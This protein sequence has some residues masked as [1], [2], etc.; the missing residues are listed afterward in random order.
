MSTCCNSADWSDCGV[1]GKERSSLRLNLFSVYFADVNVVRSALTEIGRQGALARA[2]KASQINLHSISETLKRH[3]TSIIN[4][5]GPGKI[6]LSRFL[7]CLFGFPFSRACKQAG[8]VIALSM[9]AE[10]TLL[11][12]IPVIYVQFGLTVLYSSVAIDWKI[13]V[14]PCNPWIAPLTTALS[15][16][17]TSSLKCLFHELVFV[18]GGLNAQFS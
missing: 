12:W 5:R 15:R 10:R 13:V 14:C 16:P 9:D 8:I 4:L 18:S 2:L 3:L 1:S 6:S 11:D 17:K 7:V